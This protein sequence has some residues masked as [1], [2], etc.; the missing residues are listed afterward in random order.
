MASDY[1]LFTYEGEDKKLAVERF[2]RRAGRRGADF[3]DGGALGR[4][5]EARLLLTT[6]TPI[7]DEGAA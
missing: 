1:R 5:G 3:R 7:Y 2:T 4:T 6:Y